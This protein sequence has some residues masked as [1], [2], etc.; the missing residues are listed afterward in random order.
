MRR[1]KL[2]ELP[3]LFNILRGDM[4]FVGPRPVLQEETELSPGVV[5]PVIKCVGIGVV[6]RLAAELCR[7][8]G[9]GAS[10]AA[11]E[12]CGAACAMVTVLPLIRAL[13]KLITDLT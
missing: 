2:D 5:T 11:V 4:S 10:A 8:A 9:Q 7:D 6:T 3:Q 13:L 12:V 1:L